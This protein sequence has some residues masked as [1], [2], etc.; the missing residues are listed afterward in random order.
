MGRFIIT[1]IEKYLTE[2]SSTIDDYKGEHEAPGNDGFGEPMH[3]I[4]SMYPG[5]YT[6]NAYRDYG[7]EPGAHSV[8]NLIQ[9]VHNKPNKLVTIYRAVP[10]LNK[11]ID[12]EIKKL[13]NI[14][15]YKSKYGFFP[16]KNKVVD[17]LET[18]IWENTPSLTYDQMQIEVTNSIL[19]KIDEL[20]LNKEPI[21]KINNGDWVTVSKSYTKEHG[22][23]NLLGRYKI[24]TKNVKASQLYTDGNSVFEWGYNI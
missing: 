19:K 20:S 23:S 12:K 14:I 2:K 3:N 13:K 6:S 4:T 1:D 16:M 15:D 7:S 24:I 21:I 8:I 5:I 9:S 22:V 10:D 18:S 17:D 11:D